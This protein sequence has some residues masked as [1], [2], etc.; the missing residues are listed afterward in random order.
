MNRSRK[1]RPGA[2]AMVTTKA[3]LMSLVVSPIGSAA[4]AQHA[5]SPAYSGLAG[6]ARVLDEISA[7]S[8][9]GV[10][11]AVLNSTKCIVVIP[12]IRKTT[13]VRAG[14]V[15]TC[16]DAANGWSTPAFVT[17]NG[18]GV[19]PRSTALLVF[20][21][22]E[23]GVRTLRSGELLIGGQNQAPAP[24]VKTSPVTPQV[25]LITQ[26]FT[27][28]GAA[29]VLSSSDADGV[30][31]NGGDTSHRNPNQV[32]K[33]RQRQIF[34]VGSFFLQHN[35]TNRD[36]LSPHGSNSRGKYTA[37]QRARHRQI[38]SRA[39]LR[40]L[41]FRPGL[42]RGVSLP[43]YAERH[44]ESWQTRKVRGSACGWVQL[45]PWDFTRRRFQ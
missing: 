31:R 33:E 23:Q 17:F 27:Y 1:L 35:Y 37:A 5:K 28:E 24:L 6:A 8:Q 9:N 42:P 22:S 12:L 43:D 10:P 13:N 34:V 38:S 39:R 14:G 41:V 2:L 16:R 32:V 26:L 4:R 21:L 40:D 45:I 20:I 15:A 19:R 25:E 29:G 36:R 30:I 44:S 3:L 7:K 18:H 11:D